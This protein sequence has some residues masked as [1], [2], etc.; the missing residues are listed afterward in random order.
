MPTFDPEGHIS[1]RDL[2]NIPINTPP[3]STPQPF[4]PYPNSSA[5]SLGDWFW[6][7]GVQKSQAL[8][9]IIGDPEFRVEDVRR[10]K[11]DQ[12]NKELATE[13]ESEWLDTNAGDYF[14][15]L[16]ASSWYTFYASLWT[17]GLYS[18]RFP[19]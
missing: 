17:A 19:S 9:E 10:V 7:G 1:M 3:G 12:I 4:Y 18:W 15:A 14:S 11:W 5:F 8:V 13:D 2:S 16:S 6:N